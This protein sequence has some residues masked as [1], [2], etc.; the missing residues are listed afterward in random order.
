MFLHLPNSRS[1]FRS[2]ILPERKN[3]YLLHVKKILQPM[4]VYYFDRFNAEPGSLRQSLSL[5]KCLEMFNPHGFSSRCFTAEDIRRLNTFV[6]FKGCFDAL[7]AELPN[8]HDYPSKFTHLL[9][10]Y[11]V[12]VVTKPLFHRSTNIAALPDYCSQ[13]QR[14]LR[15]FSRLS[16]ILASE[17]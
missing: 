12:F 10:F 6:P 7:V 3:R 2:M 8:I 4:M 15:G 5:F 9:I 1:V 14:H 11:H 16:I 17:E 13:A